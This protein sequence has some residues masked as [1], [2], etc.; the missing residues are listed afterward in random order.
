MLKIE[1]LQCSACVKSRVSA[2][3][4]LWI[5][6]LQCSVYAKLRV[7]AVRVLRI[8]L[9]QCSA[10]VCAEMSNFQYISDI[11]AFATKNG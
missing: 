6:L 9:L 1:L 11:G 4:V 10:C 2:V 5:E 8:G 3:R 7:N